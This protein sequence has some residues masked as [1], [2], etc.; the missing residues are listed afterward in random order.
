V[1]SRRAQPGGGSATQHPTP[2]TAAPRGRIG[3]ATPCV[4]PDRGE[5]RGH[6]HRLAR[7]AGAHTDGSAPEDQRE[8]RAHLAEQHEVEHREIAKPISSS[9]A[10]T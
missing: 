1:I 4:E 8:L 10:A 3:P 7:H 6:H 5:R 2:D 9:P